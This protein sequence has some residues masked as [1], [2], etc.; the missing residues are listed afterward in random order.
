[1]SVAP[2]IN[3]DARLLLIGGIASKTKAIIAVHH[4]EIYAEKLKIF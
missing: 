2:P 3:F 1:V 4:G